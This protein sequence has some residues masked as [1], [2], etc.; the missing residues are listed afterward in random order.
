MIKKLNPAAS[1]GSRIS[2]ICGKNGTWQEDL[3]VI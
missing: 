2:D 1:N 3:T